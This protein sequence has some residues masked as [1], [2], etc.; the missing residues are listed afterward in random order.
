[1]VDDEYS[2]SYSGVKVT[3]NVIT[4][5]KLFNLGIG[6]GAYVWS[7]DDPNLLHG[8]ATISGNTIKGNVAF[9]IAVNGW[10]N[11]LTVSRLWLF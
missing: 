6:I 3:N 11:G 2:G 7:F 9:A 10:D 4:G 5:E 8:P 1:M